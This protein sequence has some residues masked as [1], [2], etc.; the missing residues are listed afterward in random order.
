MS[1]NRNKN[2]F[3]NNPLEKLLARQELWSARSKD[4]KFVFG[5]E[6]HL[7]E[8]SE[9]LAVS[10]KPLTAPFLSAP[11]L[12]EIDQ[13]L[14]Q[15]GLPFGEIHEWSFKHLEKAN[16]AQKKNWQAPI[17]IFLFLISNSLKNSLQDSHPEH[18]QRK[19]FFIGRRC[20]PTP[21]ALSEYF[22]NENS[23][24]NTNSQKET[25]YNWRENCFFIDPP[26]KEQRLFSSVLA[27]QSRSVLAVIS[28]I[29]FSSLIDSRRMKLAAKKSGALGL[30]FR[31]PWENQS[32][33]LSASAASTRWELAASPEGWKLNLSYAK[34]CSVPK[35]WF[36]KESFALPSNKK[37]PLR[38]KEQ[39]F[40]YLLS[41]T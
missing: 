19:I 28:D 34:G 3:E 26:D 37:T 8:S 36:L 6:T 10:K 35:Q 1:T 27:L 4:K 12:S 30:L 39:G 23:S 33:K 16:Y 20:W 13:Y 21:H 38:T 5:G 25:L 32:S 7:L 15:G 41:K 17:S 14:G 18:H 11:F 22:S 40:N 24:P 2:N 29:S 9:K 31:S